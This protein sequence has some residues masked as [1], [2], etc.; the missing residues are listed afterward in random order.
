VGRL[1]FGFGRTGD[2]TTRHLDASGGQ[3][4]TGRIDQ[5]IFT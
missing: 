2:G 1:T 5:G 4:L 3:L